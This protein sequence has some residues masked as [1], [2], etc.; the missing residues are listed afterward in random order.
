MRD[1]ITV[2][3]SMNHDIILK[4][5]RLPKPDETLPTD[6]VTFS[7]GGKGANQA[8]QAAKLGVKTCMVGCVGEDGHGDFLLESVG[9]YGLDTSHIRRVKQPTGMAVIDVVEDGSLFSRLVRGANMAV[10]KA[11]VDAAEALLR[12]TEI[13]ILQMEIPQETNMYA[14]DRARECGCRVLLNTAPAM[15]IPEEYLGKCDIIVANEVEAAFY[16]KEAVSDV[17]HAKSGAKKLADAYGADIILTLGKL[18]SIVC[19]SGEITYLPAHEV[20]AIETT[21]A[22]DSFIG[23]I[24][25]GLMQ[26]MSLTKACE[27]A[28]SCSAVTV[29]R[30]GAQA[31]M[32]TLAEVMS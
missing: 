5:P 16:L 21:G 3:G 12:E 30:L 8:V 20:D 6:N 4:I 17:E 29:C 28:T 26:G 1:K 32:P 24:A 19:E 11:D 13:V 23:G 31:S 9:K 18:G 22:G 25:Y 10:G 2:I 27:F 14:I 15:E 7:A